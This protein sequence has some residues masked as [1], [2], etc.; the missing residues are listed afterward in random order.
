MPSPGSP[1]PAGID[2]A[3]TT[4]TAGWCRLPRTRGDRP[5]PEAIRRVMVR[6]PP[7]PRG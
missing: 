4:P 1:A 3:A 2:P 6:A 5:W 7:H